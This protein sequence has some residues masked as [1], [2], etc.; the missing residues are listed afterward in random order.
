[1]NDATVKIGYDG[2]ALNAGLAASDAKLN[3]FAQKT[4]SRFSKLGSKM[5]SMLKGGAM[6][7]VAAIGAG[8]VKAVNSAGDLLDLS[9]RLNASAES[10]QRLDLMASKKGTDVETITAAIEKLNLAL[11]DSAEGPAAKAFQALGIEASNLARLEPDKQLIQLAK[12]YQEAESSGTGYAEII[13]V[14][15][16]NANELLPLLRSNVSELEALAGGPVASEADLERMK[17]HVEQVG[18]AISSGVKLAGDAARAMNT[19]TFSDEQTAAINKEIAAREK[20][21]DTLREVKAAQ[22]ETAGSTEKL[23]E[24]NIKS[25]EEARKEASTKLAGLG[26]L[27]QE[28]ALL[29][30]KARGKDKAASKMEKELN[31]QKRAAE[32]QSQLGLD[33]S[34]ARSVATREADAQEQISRR[35]QGLRPKIKGYTQAQGAVRGFSGLDAYYKLQQ[36]DVSGVHFDA[37]DNGTSR[38]AR[39]GGQLADTSGSLSGRRGRGNLSGSSLSASS[40]YTGMSVDKAVRRD[41]ALAKAATPETVPDKLDKLIEVTTRGLLE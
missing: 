17:I 4:E 3:S 1:M 11:A 20:Q 33:P 41:Q 8:V 34:M 35:E 36:R 7:V 6:A 32:L 37:F 21:R 5:G 39:K 30:L 15:G 2:T 24:A 18:K 26:M 28:L 14:I 40:Q 31:I 38:F 22:I 12:A 9:E 10:V 19:A 25:A 23:T 27:K 16:K 29:E 13:A